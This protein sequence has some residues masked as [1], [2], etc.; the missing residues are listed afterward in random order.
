M[1]YYLRGE[2][3]VRLIQ[4]L[5]TISKNDAVSNHA[6]MIKN[7]LDDLA[8]ENEIIAENIDPAL[9]REA[10]EI[11][12]YKK[13]QGDICIYHF[14]IV[15]HHVFELL[16]QFDGVKMM[17]YHNI[18]PPEYFKKWSGTLYQAT[19][20]ALKQIRSAK[21]LFDLVVA[22]SNF[23]RDDLL[24]YGFDNVHV[25]PLRSPLLNLQN[26]N[27]DHLEKNRK[28][29]NTILFV[30]RI[31]P[32]KNPESLLRVFYYYQKYFFP[33]SSLEL[34]GSYHGMEDYLEYLKLLSRHLGL[35]NVAFRGMINTNDLIKAY[36]SATIFLSMSE[37]EG[38]GV[39]IQ[40]AMH[41]R[42]PIL[43]LNAGAISE[44][45]HTGGLLIN[46]KNY[47]YIAA[48]AN[49]L[50]KN[51]ELRKVI[52]EQQK[53]VIHDKYSIENTSVKRILELLS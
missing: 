30:G 16:Q 25:I 12:E 6:L 44:T 23:N 28:K 2:T 14:S 35:E 13:K 32:N 39:P 7:E 50:Y 8:I 22:D 40:E 46:E 18:T 20:Q 41:F 37:H 17:I 9:Y 3:A 27:S 19:S 38:F 45:L 42:L 47:K 10:K 4:L 49:I 34:I 51:D 24:S 29:N 1:A 21:G 15:S 52:Q 26:R 36:Q 11:K 33:D 5:P 31:A 48:L 53:L 43:A